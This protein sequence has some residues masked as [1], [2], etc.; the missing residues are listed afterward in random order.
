[1]QPLLHDRYGP[2]YALMG[3]LF[4]STTSVLAEMAFVDL[5]HQ[6]SSDCVGLVSYIQALHVR[7]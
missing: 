7:S 3:R 2:T 6:Q 1:M 4:R 5:V